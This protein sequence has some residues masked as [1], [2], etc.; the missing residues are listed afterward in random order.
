MHM[1]FLMSKLASETLFLLNLVQMLYS[2]TPCFLKY[3]VIYVRILRSYAVPGF[4][5]K[6]TERWL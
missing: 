2:N 1:S 4:E 5:T 6:P 3:L